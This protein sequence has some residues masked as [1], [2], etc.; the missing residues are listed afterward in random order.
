MA[1]RS[2]SIGTAGA[3]V[4]Y[5][6]YKAD[7]RDYV[8][9]GA[10]WVAV[11]SL[12]HVQYNAC[13][14]ALS[15]IS[16]SEGETGRYRHTLPAWSVPVL[17]EYYI[18]VVSETAVPAY[19]DMYDPTNE[20]LVADWTDGGRLDLILDHITILLGTPVGVDT[21]A[22]TIAGML[23]ALLARVGT[24]LQASLAAILEDT[25][26]TL[27]M[28]V[29]GASPTTAQ[30]ADAVL[31][32]VLTEHSVAAS[33][34]VAINHIQTAVAATGDGAV[35]IDHDYGGADK[36]AYRL[37]SGVGIDNAV[38]RAYLSAD[39]A[40]GRYGPAYVQ[41]TVYTDVYGRWRSPMA[42]DPGTYTLQY[43]K[44]GIRGPDTVTVVVEAP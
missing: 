41:A 32:A 42:L 34:A 43:V 12:T 2:I 6:A 30:I 11:T 14:A 18:G 5:R 31:D 8:W 10:A 22:A 21:Q 16:T 17:L 39:Y 1:E 40:A 9:N 27:P 37:A 19:V 36:L 13:A 29:A 26:T 15:A 44:Q 3:T 23:V 33:L 7:N 28:L 20:A 4:S 25:G 35:M 38:I 24:T